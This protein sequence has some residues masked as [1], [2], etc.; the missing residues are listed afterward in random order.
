MVEKEEFG[1]FVKRIEFD[2]D[3]YAKIC[4]RISNGE[5]RVGAMEIKKEFDRELIRYNRITTGPGYMVTDDTGLTR[6]VIEAYP[7]G[8]TRIVKKE[9]A[10]GLAKAL[11][12]SE[13]D[14]VEI[15]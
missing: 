4:R 3:Y 7:G 14:V 2:W 13:K 11:G 1:K 6:D 10:E 15:K 12:Y 9:D 5:K 8:R